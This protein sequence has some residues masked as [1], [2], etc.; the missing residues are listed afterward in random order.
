MLEEN[1]PQFTITPID[2]QQDSPTQ[3]IV[4]AEGERVIQPS[5]V[6]VQDLQEQQIVQPTVA[7]SELAQPI[8][9][10]VQQSAYPQPSA[11]ASSGMQ[12]GMSASQLG[13]NQPK[14]D[15]NLKGLF[16][17]VAMGLVV[18]GGVFAALV[19]TNVVALSE[20]KT[21]NYTNSSGTHYTFEFY[22]K[23]SSKTLNSGNTQLVSKVSKGGKFPIHCLLQ[24]AILLTW[25]K[26]V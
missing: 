20:F 12:V 26:T 25:T 18:I 3:P 5:R 23:H 16:I 22:S 4:G 7:N 8:Q 2:N 19:I 15:F 24:R 17:K 6:L 11:P 13:L 14:R 1:T 9:S 21:V 10:T